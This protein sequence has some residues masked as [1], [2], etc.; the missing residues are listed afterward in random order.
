MSRD[1][2]CC[3]LIKISEILGG[4][5]RFGMR[6]RFD[7]FEHGGPVKTGRYSTGESPPIKGGHRGTIPQLGVYMYAIQHISKE[8][9]ETIRA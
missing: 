9:N 7:H 6:Q 1:R 3:G 8:E 2:D 5:Q 4:R